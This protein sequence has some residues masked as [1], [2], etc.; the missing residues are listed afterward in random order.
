VTTTSHRSGLGLAVL[1]AAAFGTSG[2]CGSAL[3]DAGWSP[4]AAVTARITV[5]ALVLTW[6]A[7]AALRGRWALLRRSAGQVLAY[8]AV[9]VVACQLCYFNALAHLPVGVALLL[10]YLGSVLVVGWLWLRHGQRPRRLTVTGTVAALGGLVLVLNLAG[11]GGGLSVVGVVWAL[12]AAVA[13]AV[14]FMLSA[15]DSAEPLPSV[16]MVCGG[17]WTGAVL[18]A[19]GGL[20]HAVP[21]TAS[22]RDVQLLGH[23]VSWIVPVLGLSLLATALAYVSGVGA[24]RDLGAKLASFVGMAEVL[25][26]V[27]YA[28]LLLHQI[29]SALQFGGGV[30]ILAGVALVRLDELR[31]GP[32]PAPPPPAGQVPAEPV[33]TVR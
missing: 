20:V 18:L 26:A 11:S 6:P 13:L 7:L 12:G 14:Y 4:A 10:E 3:V 29:P 19:V 1:S 30:L 22:T 31:G 33:A 28:W 9:G 5:A 2:T 24:A 16:V 27:A 15:A 32:A 21:M 25:F 23:R 8:G 17:A